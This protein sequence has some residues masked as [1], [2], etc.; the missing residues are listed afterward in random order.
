MTLTE[1]FYQFGRW[2][3]FCA[4]FFLSLIIL[5]AVIVDTVQKILHAYYVERKKFIEM[6]TADAKATFRQ[7]DEI[8]NNKLN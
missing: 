6:L 7:L 4:L 5:E 2:L 1:F 3:A 8:S